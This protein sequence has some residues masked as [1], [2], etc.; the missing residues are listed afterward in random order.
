MIVDAQW[1]IRK[2]DV[3]KRAQANVRI[4]GFIVKPV[5]GRAFARPVGDTPE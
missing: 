4:S 1:R 5:I 3:G 2:R